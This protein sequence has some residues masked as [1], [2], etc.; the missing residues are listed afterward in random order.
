MAA[1][2]D[3]LLLADPCQGCDVSSAHKV[4]CCMAKQWQTGKCLQDCHHPCACAFVCRL[5]PNTSIPDTV[6]FTVA[7]VTC[8]ACRCSID[9]ECLVG[10]RQLKNLRFLDF[11]TNKIARVDSLVPLSPKLTAL[12]LAGNPLDITPALSPCLPADAGMSAHGNPT[13]DACLELQLLDAS[14]LMLP[15]PSLLSGLTMLTGLHA[16]GTRMSSRQ[17]RAMLAAIRQMPNMRC[18]DLSW[19]SDGFYDPPPRSAWRGLPA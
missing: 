2:V 11:S 18:L 13:T 14:G 6:K 10:I 19:R 12:V 1:A 4:A 9:H 3:S 5:T 7:S 15:D 16:A 8:C 17:P